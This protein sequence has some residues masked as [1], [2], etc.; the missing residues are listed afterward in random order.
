MFGVEA[1][2]RELLKRKSEWSFIGPNMI[3]DD[4]R[5]VLRNNKYDNPSFK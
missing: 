5:V 2:E 4:I 1:N 3:G